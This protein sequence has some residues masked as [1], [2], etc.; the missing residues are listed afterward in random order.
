MEPRSLSL[1]LMNCPRRSF[2]FG[3]IF[4]A[5]RLYMSEVYFYEN[6][7]RSDLFDTELCKFKGAHQKHWISMSI[8]AVSGVRRPHR[9]NRRV[10]EAPTYLAN[11]IGA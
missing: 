6:I 7:G 11:Q 9:F 4:S 8:K 5:L 2:F 1:A 10:G 3:K